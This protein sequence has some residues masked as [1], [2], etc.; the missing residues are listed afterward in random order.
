MTLNDADAGYP[1]AY[2]SFTPLTITALCNTTGW[3]A[4][5]QTFTRD[6]TGT[7]GDEAFSAVFY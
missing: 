5:I 6:T 4:V 3:Q 1:V 2:I 7:E